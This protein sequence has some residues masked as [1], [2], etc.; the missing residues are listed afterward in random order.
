MLENNSL[1][2]ENILKKLLIWGSYF[3]VFIPAIFIPQSYFPYV[4]QKT[5]LLRIVIEL[6]FGIY[7]VLVLFNRKYL[8]KKSFL[9]WSLIAFFVVM[10]VTTFTGDSIARSWWGNWERMMGT[11]NYLHYFV[12][13]LILISVFKTQIAWKRILDFSLV[14]S[15]VICLYGIAQ[16]LGLNFVFEAG[17]DRV[18]S[19]IG[20]ASLLSSYLIFHLFISLLYLFKVKDIK[21]KIFYIISFVLV[22]INIF[23][24]ATRGA[25]LALFISLI[26][27]IIFSLVLKLWRNNKGIKYMLIGVSIL[28][29]L[30]SSLF[31]LRSN[32]FIKD[33]YFLNRLT[34]Y[35]LEDNTVQ[36][37]LLSWQAGYE[38]FKDNLLL[39]VGSENFQNVFNEYINPEFYDYTGDEV[40]FDRSHNTVIDI[41]VMMGIFGLLSYLS[42]FIAL[43][44][45][46][47][48]LLKRKLLSDS[49][50]IILSLLFITY[51]IQNLFVFDSLNSLILFYLLLAFVY[52]L[53]IQDNNESLNESKV[54]ARPIL[55]IPLVII[56]FTWLF[57]SINLV[58]VKANNSI[59]ET[60]RDKGRVDYETMVEHYKQAA[61]VAVNKIDPAHLFSSALDESFYNQ[62]FFASPETKISN[63]K[64]AASLMDRA[65]DLDSSNMY[66]Y[67][68]QSKNYSHLFELTGDMEYFDKGLYF[69]VESKEYAANRIRP[70]WVIAQMYLLNEQYDLAIENIDI[71]INI[72]E[73]TA[74]NYYYKSIIYKAQGNVD[75][76]GE[77]YKKMMEH[78]YPFSNNDIFELLNYFDE[79]QDVE[80]LINVVTILTEIDPTDLN[81]WNNLVGLYV[82]DL[83][84]EEA[85]VILKQASKINPGYSYNALQSY[86]EIEQ[87]IKNQYDEQDQ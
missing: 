1:K 60:F 52:S 46:L 71:A 18:K 11:F 4:I 83:Q 72:N 34:N 17:I 59:F 62:N 26:I 85:L 78:N 5:I 54:L 31:A 32:S 80:Q 9:L 58:E 68:I 47:I 42:I 37:R 12:W 84:Y 39:G 64:I 51:F 76:Q 6:L 53:Y 61:D 86:K 24:A 67:Y 29:L 19:T 15:I 45:Y 79:R 33:N 10:L 70:Y 23:L 16:M 44:Y 13:F 38:G 14:T 49:S 36:T 56:S 43:F 3:I 2:L 40:W 35:S 30:G 21:Y 69:A 55:T 63:F 82:M 73:G 65:L 48:N 50:F 8:P 28:V 77:M 81:H 7:L 57:F 74:Q 20:N 87:L 66:L 22:L 25:Q 75:G 27:F 41:G